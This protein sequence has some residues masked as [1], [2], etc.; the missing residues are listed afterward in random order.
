M[1]KRKTLE[2]QGKNFHKPAIPD[3]KAGVILPLYNLHRQQILH[4]TIQILILT[5]PLR[6][7]FPVIMPVLYLHRHT[8]CKYIVSVL[9]GKARAMIGSSDDEEATL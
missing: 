2:I 5:L 8:L 1:K 4:M 6:A 3:I 9:L 7:V